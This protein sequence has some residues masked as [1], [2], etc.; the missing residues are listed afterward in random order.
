MYIKDIYSIEDRKKLLKSQRTQNI[1][2][3]RK[4]DEGISK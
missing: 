3:K 1:E 4:E 2:I